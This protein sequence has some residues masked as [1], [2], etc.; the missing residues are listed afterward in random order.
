MGNSTLEGKKVTGIT[1]VKALVSEGMIC[2]SLF[3]SF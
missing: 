3:G 2:S 1:V